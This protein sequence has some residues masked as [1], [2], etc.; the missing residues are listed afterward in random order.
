MAVK[1]VPNQAF[2]EEVRR[3]RRYGV[4]NSFRVEEKIRGTLT[5]GGTRSVPDWLILVCPGL[6]SYAPL[7]LSWW[8]LRRDFRLEILNFKRRGIVVR[9]EN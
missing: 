3:Q 8:R 1:R 9:A 7:G 5:Q 6:L 4:R 2:S